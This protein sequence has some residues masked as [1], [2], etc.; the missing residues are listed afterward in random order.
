MMQHK[1]E[2]VNAKKIKEPSGLL[3]MQDN[4]I[5]VIASLGEVN[6]IITALNVSI[7]YPANNIYTTKVINNAFG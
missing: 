1:V 2:T 4:S 7:L 5:R 6:Y 3:C